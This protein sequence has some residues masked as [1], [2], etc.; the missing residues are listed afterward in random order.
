MFLITLY[1][2]SY[3]RINLYNNLFFIKEI[4]KVIRNRCEDSR[5]NFKIR[6]VKKQKS[7]EGIVGNKIV[8]MKAAEYAR[9][10][11]F[12]RTCKVPTSSVN[13]MSAEIGSLNIDGHDSKYQH[14][15]LFLYFPFFIFLTF[16]YTFALAADDY[17][18]AEVHKKN[19]DILG[20][21]LALAKQQRRM[22]SSGNLVLMHII[23]KTLV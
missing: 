9:A 4:Y 18:G 7:F 13:V 2:T 1:K 10:I 12:R 22:T 16:F 8:G 21:R 14:G 3:Y 19:Q 17:D 6:V 5:R 11:T 23:K 20:Q 15:L